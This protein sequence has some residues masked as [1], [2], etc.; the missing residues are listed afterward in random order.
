MNVTLVIKILKMHL[1]VELYT[2]LASV[3]TRPSTFKIC[4]FRILPLTPMNTSIIVFITLYDNCLCV[5][6]PD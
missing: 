3:L 2:V 6:L 4:E 5:Y 1:T